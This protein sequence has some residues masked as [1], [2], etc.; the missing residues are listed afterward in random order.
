MSI[1]FEGHVG[2]WTP[3]DVEQ[4]ADSGDHSRYELL[5][6]GVLTV[7]PAPGT[8]HQRAS[9]RIANLLDDAATRAGQDVEVL[10]A[11][12]VE[13]GDGRLAVPDVAIVVGAVA[14]RNPVRYPPGSVLLVVEIVSPGSE[15][16]DRVIKP[17]LYA[18]A[19]VPAYWRFELDDPRIVVH[20]LGPERQFVAT[21]IAPAG[22]VTTIDDPFPIDFDP[23]AL[24]VR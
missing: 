19:G 1:A 13:T 3:S 4:L 6:P 14:D 12:N 9:R 5:T 22:T 2:P 24:V 15:P 20:E 17:R 23:G 8:V 11:I 21:A 7:T 18:A 10:E 16:Q